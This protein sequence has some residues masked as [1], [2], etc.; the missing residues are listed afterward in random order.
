MI[1]PVGQFQAMSERIFTFPDAW[2]GSSFELLLYF[3][4]AADVL[5]LEA[6]EELWN[7]PQLAGCWLDH[8]IEPS[9]QTR[10]APTMANI[11]LGKTYR[12]IATLPEDSRVACNSVNINDEDGS[13]LYFGIPIGSLRRAYPVGAYPFDDG[14]PTDWII[15]VTDWFHEIADMVFG[16]FPF[17]AGTIGWLTGIDL[18]VLLD[19]IRGQ[20]PGERWNGILRRN[21]A[22]LEWY[23]PTQLGPAIY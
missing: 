13:W 20:I 8:N 7:L 3:G 10:L 18:C 12:G 6:I 5:V 14:T 19:V 4:H 1:R 21:G 2:N 16:S 11:C 23:S 22:K 15:P 17:E 9:A